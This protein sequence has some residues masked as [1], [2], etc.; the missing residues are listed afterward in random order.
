MGSSFFVPIHDPTT[1][2]LLVVALL[3]LSPM[4]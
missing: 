3:T 4:S 1:G 2:L